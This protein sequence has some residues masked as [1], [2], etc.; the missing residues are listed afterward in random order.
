MTKYSQLKKAI[1]LARHI[2]MLGKIKDFEFKDEDFDIYKT[3]PIDEAIRR[4]GWNLDHL[5]KLV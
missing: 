4:M 3:M 1:R 2:Q 5:I